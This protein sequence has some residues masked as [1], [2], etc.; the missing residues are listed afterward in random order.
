MKYMKTYESHS[1][2]DTNLMANAYRDFFKQYDYYSSIK[3][4]PG[5]DVHRIKS[6]IVI[7]DYLVYSITIFYDGLKDVDYIT[8]TIE[9]ISSGDDDKNFDMKSYTKLDVDVIL[10]RYK[11]MI[12]EV[13]TI[14][15]SKEI[16]LL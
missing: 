9:Y 2:S 14:I 1:E 4:T 12:E 7:G 11:E 13:K 16:G 3:S 10:N 15:D 6:L 5:T 8:N